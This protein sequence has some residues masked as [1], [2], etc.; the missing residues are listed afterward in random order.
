LVGDGVVRLLRVEIER[1]RSIKDQWIPGEGLVVLFGLNSGGKASVLEAVENV[2]TQASAVRADPGDSRLALRVRP[3]DAGVQRRQLRQQFPLSHQ[4]L[5]GHR[6]DLRRLVGDARRGAGLPPVSARIWRVVSSP[7]RSAR[8]NDLAHM[9]GSLPAVAS[10]SRATECQHKNSAATPSRSLHSFRTLAPSSSNCPR[11][12]F[13]APARAL[14][15]PAC[16]RASP[17]ARN[18]WPVAPV[19]ASRSSA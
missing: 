6:A 13:A 12:V 1:F 18:A 2:I 16:A 19:T 15:G 17:A 9:G 7:W 10:R 5:H 8:V 14:T 11:K 3:P 4:S